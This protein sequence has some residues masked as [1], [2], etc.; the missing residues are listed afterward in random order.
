MKGRNKALM[1]V[2]QGVDERTFKNMKLFLQ[3]P[4]Q[5]AAIVV[6]NNDDAD[7][8]IFD[9]DSPTSKK[10]LEQHL[11]E[12]VRKPVIVLSLSGVGAQD[13]VIT[14]KKPV[15]TDVMLKGLNQANAL[16]RAYSKKGFK[17]VYSVS[18]K[19]QIRDTAIQED[20]FDDWFQSQN[21][22]KK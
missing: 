5:G 2:I 12:G 21:L 8:Y 16:I 18:G 22:T 1:V 14:V 6:S 10:L 7:V 15:N 11:Q 4:C 17:E 19:P 3:G 20:W 13:G 9:A